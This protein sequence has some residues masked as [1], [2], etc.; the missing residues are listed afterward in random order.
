[1]I[2]A[3]VGKNHDPISKITG[4]KKNGRV[5]QVVEHLPSKQETLGPNTT[6]PKRK[7]IFSSDGTI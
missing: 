5:A 1:V 4:V 7:K 3:S 2:Q 6:L